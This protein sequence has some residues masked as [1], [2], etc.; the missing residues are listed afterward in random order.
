MRPPRYL[1]RR[2]NCQST[3]L[4]VKSARSATNVSET[5]MK[6]LAMP[7]I[8]QPSR[9]AARMWKRY[10]RHAIP[11]ARTAHHVFQWKPRGPPEPIDGETSEEQDR[12]RLEK[13]ELLIEPRGAERDLRGR[14]AAIAT[15]RRGLSRKALRDR[16]P[17]CGRQ[18][19]LVDPCLREP[20]SELRAGATAE[21]STGGQLDLARRLPHDRDAIANGSCDD[22]AGSLEESGVDAFRARA[23]SGLQ[24]N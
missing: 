2:P 20:S 12:S 1:A 13:R 15:S 6:K 4:L 14:W 24:T 7:R 17:V 22:G 19:L 10:V 11:H 18:M 23:D 21:G 3:C 9:G 5:F 8:V 16:G